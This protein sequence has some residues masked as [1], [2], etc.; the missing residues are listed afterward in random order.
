MRDSWRKPARM[1]H[2]R[3]LMLPFRKVA[4][5]SGKIGEMICLTDEDIKMNRTW[6]I[7]LAVIVVAIGVYFLYFAAED[8]VVVAPAPAPV[9]APVAEPDPITPEPE[10]PGPADAAA[11]EEA[12][13]PE[14]DAAPEAVAPEADAAAEPDAA[15]V[16][17]DDDLAE[18]TT[19]GPEEVTTTDEV[20]TT[21]GF[22]FERVRA[23]IEGAPVS[24]EEKASLI[25][26]LERTQDSP[27]LLEPVL[28]QVRALLG[29]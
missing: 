29:L 13:A 5:H 28:E 26:A 15:V 17:G 8:D 2:S 10:E 18:D 19:S 4:C 1:L 9:E 14:A 12:V 3:A 22:D 27:A 16:D 25:A 11:P 23:M 6:I 20:L 21:D 7:A 24:E